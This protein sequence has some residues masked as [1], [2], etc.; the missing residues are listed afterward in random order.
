VEV[1]DG[2]KIKCNYE[3]CDKV[4]N[5]SNIHF[6]TPSMVTHIRDNIAPEFSQCE[7]NVGK[8]RI[9]VALSEI[10]TGISGTQ[11]RSFSA[12]SSLSQM[13]QT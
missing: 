12:L 3:S 5:K 4:V 1:S 13:G 10:R 7:E 11:V 6:K 8:L 2:A 9:F